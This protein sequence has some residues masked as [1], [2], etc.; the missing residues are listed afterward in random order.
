MTDDELRD[1]LRGTDPA[2]SLEPLSQDQVSQLLG[3]M[4]DEERAPVSRPGLGFWSGKGK[5]LVAALVLAAAAAGVFGAVWTD[6]ES[7]PTLAP[8]R[9][10]LPAIADDGMQ[11]KCA[12]PTVD[13][14]RTS[15]LAVQGRVTG[16]SDA[17]VTIA[18]SRVWSGSAVDVLEVT[19]TSGASELLLGG[20]AFEVGQSY[21]LSVQDGEVRG[22]GFSGV[23][24]PEL[25]ALFEEA[26]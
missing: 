24:S 12:P 17:V 11:A 14:L 18:V 25:E 2:A 3:S 15:E 19:Q 6:S 8:V 7:D 1:Q 16:V 23:A 21:L 13:E 5:P 22:C 4:M 26:F 9:V 10:A 20:T